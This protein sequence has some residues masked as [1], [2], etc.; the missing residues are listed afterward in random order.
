MTIDTIE[1]PRA[2][3]VAGKTSNW[4][5]TGWLFMR[6]SGVLLVILI[7]GHLFTNLMVG[8]GISAIDFAFVGGKLSNPFW[9]VWDG[10][11]LVLAFIHGA[12][13]MRT[14]INDYIDRPGARQALHIVLGIATVVLIVL[15]LLVIITFDPCPANAPADLLPGF[16]TAR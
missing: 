12:N 4:E 6:G 7:F 11:M 3:R 10:L 5:R 1:Y 13:G 2:A 15:G 16:C 8:A 9:Q 14:I